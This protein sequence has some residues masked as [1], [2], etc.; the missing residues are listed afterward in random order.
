MSITQFKARK[1]RKATENASP[2]PWK[3]GIGPDLLLRIASLGPG[4][5]GPTVCTLDGSDEETAGADARFLVAAREAMPR[6]LAEP[7]WVPI[8]PEA[9][10]P[11][12]NQL[13]LLAV[14]GRAEPVVVTFTHF[15]NEPH[16]GGP[17]SGNVTYWRALPSPPG[18]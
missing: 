4:D 18:V 2:G 13:I 1:W 7:F 12:E 3:A 16:W 10:L 11:Q 8:G 15:R 14:E 5:A 17:Q 9:R 6:L